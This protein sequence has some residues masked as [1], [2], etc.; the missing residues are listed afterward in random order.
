MYTAKDY[1]DKAKEGPL[2]EWLRSFVR[3]NT[4]VIVISGAARCP[5][6][7]PAIF[8]WHTSHADCLAPSRPRRSRQPG[9]RLLR[10]H[11]ITY[12]FSRPKNWAV[13]DPCWVR[14]YR[15]Y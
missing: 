2:G 5:L 6:Y 12:A 14:V 15:L 11:D 7:L 3:C 9:Q 1:I 13:A 4:K 10:T 8:M